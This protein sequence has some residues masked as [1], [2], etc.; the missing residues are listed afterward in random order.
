MLSLEVFLQFL[1]EI[2]CCQQ[3]FIF[4]MSYYGIATAKVF[5]SYFDILGFYT[6][7]IFT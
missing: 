6:E 7:K 5:F 1:I 3:N 2:F 4:L